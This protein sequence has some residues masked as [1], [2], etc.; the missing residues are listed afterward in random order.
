MEFIYLWHGVSEVEGRAAMN[1][2]LSDAAAAGAAGA[3]RSGHT[4]SQA[5]VPCLLFFG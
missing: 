1:W 3:A 2:V 5:E 4:A